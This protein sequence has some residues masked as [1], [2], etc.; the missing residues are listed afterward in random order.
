MPPH[1]SLESL[2]LLILQLELGPCSATG[3]RVS[4]SHMGIWFSSVCWEEQQWDSGLHRS[5]DDESPP[6]LKNVL[7]WS[8]GVLSD[9]DLFSLIPTHMLTPPGASLVVGMAVQQHRDLL[10]CSTAAMLLNWLF[11][12]LR[13]ARVWSAWG[14]RWIHHSP[15]AWDTHRWPRC[16]RGFGS[17]CS[18]QMKTSTLSLKPC[19]VCCQQRGFP[20]KRGW[21]LCRFQQF[22]FVAVHG[23]WELL[24]LTGWR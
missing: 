7:I 21:Q 3:I 12:H 23:C 4:A 2:F 5:L 16:H 6:R 20:L 13:P 14:R 9:K 11:S 15:S 24:Q 1:F 8:P 18:M 17:A 19:S 22:P 10:W